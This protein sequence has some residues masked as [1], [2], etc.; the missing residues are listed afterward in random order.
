MRGHSPTTLPP[1]SAYVLL[2]LLQLTVINK[3]LVTVITTKVS[4][5]PCVAHKNNNV[6]SV[7]A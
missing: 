3:L 6:M 1:F 4:L 7:H 5:I 2:L